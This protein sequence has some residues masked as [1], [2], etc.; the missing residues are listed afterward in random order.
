MIVA[1][2][3]RENKRHLGQESRSKGQGFSAQK[4]SSSKGILKLC[5]RNDKDA[6]DLFFLT[7]KFKPGPL[8][9]KCISLKYE[10]LETA[11]SGITPLEPGAT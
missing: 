9:I 4:S 10:L 8:V 7:Q 6:L 2:T 3:E 5:G 11:V 1:H